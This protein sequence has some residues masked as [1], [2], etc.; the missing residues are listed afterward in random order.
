[1]TASNSTAPTTATPELD[2]ADIEAATRA[3]LKTTRTQVSRAKAKAKR[4]GLADTVQKSATI[5]Y[6]NDQEYSCYRPPFV[7]LRKGSE[8][9]ISFWD[10]P[11]CI[12]DKKYGIGCEIGRNLAR[13]YIHH[14]MSYNPSE[15]CGFL[16]RVVLDMLDA[17]QKL[18][19]QRR[20][21]IV[22]FFLILEKVLFD[23]I[24]DADLSLHGSP[25]VWLAAVNAALTRKGD[26]PKK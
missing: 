4:A 6:N 14:V 24:E 20:G 25:S 23:A 10:V 3:F 18:S 8:G 15:E 11:E 9:G 1:M 19:E 12:S 22:G 26:D 17:D 21:E 2:T 5:T 7:K 16:Q 13:I